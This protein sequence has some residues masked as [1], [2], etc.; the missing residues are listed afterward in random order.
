MVVHPVSLR[1]VPAK[2]TADTGVLDCDGASADRSDDT[3]GVADLLASNSCW[4]DQAFEHHAR[5]RALVKAV[6]ARQAAAAKLAK[7]AK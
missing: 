2:L 6:R 5:F 7:S 3:V 1:N 4:R